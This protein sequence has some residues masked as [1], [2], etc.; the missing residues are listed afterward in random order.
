MDPA[1]GY[2]GADAPRSGLAPLLWCVVCGGESA[3]LS[4]QAG[5]ALAVAH[6][7]VA[8]AT[9]PPTRLCRGPGAFARPRRTRRSWKSWLERLEQQTT[10]QVKLLTVPNTGGEDVFQFTQRQ[11]EAWQLGPRGKATAC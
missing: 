1:R 11:F 9:V 2:Q 5:D 7:A 4:A 6:D 3:A 8:V 10:A